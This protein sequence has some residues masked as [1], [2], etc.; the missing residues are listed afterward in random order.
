MNPIRKR[1]L[2]SRR[3]SRHQAA[4]EKGA[5]NKEKD[6]STDQLKRIYY[7]ITVVAPTLMSADLSKEDTI[8]LTSDGQKREISAA[9]FLAMFDETYET[10]LSADAIPEKT[11]N[12]VLWR[13]YI[14]YALA[15][16]LSKRM[17][18]LQDVLTDRQTEAWKAAYEAFNT[19]LD[20]S[21]HDPAMAGTALFYLANIHERGVLD[22]G[23]PD[24]QKAYTLYQRAADQGYALAYDKL[25]YLCFRGLGVER[26]VLMAYVWT[27]RAFAEIQ[28]MPPAR[29]EAIYRN[30]TELSSQVLHATNIDKDAPAP[31]AT[32]SI[33][34]FDTMDAPPPRRYALN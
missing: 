21:T 12:V 18:R 1:A 22:G 13:G 31:H 3:F 5:P 26:S 32:R 19:L 28:K 7:C 2:S 9:E 16:S 10:L 27:K 24:Y 17:I 4:I 11:N 14:N 23:R 30:L 8:T 20:Q 6:L 15:D 34:S 29:A 33:V 25:S